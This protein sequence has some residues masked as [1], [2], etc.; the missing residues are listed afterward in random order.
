MSR[1]GRVVGQGAGG[2]C[3]EAGGEPCRAG[4]RF[5]AGSVSKQFVAASALLLSGHGR[6]GLADPVARW[7][8]PAPPAWASM[9]VGHLLANSSGLPHWQGIPGFDVSRPPAPQEILLQAARLPLLSAPG[10]RWAYSGVGYLLAAAIVE[11]AS[12]QPYASFVTGNVFGPLAMT[13][14]TSGEVPG[15]GQAAKGHRDG[16]PVP[17]AAELT[18][19]PGTGDVWTTA[20]DLVRYADA[21]RGGELLPRSSWQLMGHPQVKIEDSLSQAGTIWISAYGYGIY[22]GSIAGHPALFHTG[23]NPG[24]RSLLAW[25]PQAD[26]TFAV[27]ANDESTDLEDIALRLVRAARK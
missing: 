25:L 16:Q 11:A 5:Q 13:A 20:G 9:T 19:M 17:L 27:L 8:A 18:A 26:M 7:W 22:I 4:T 1:R 23:D 2:S 10:T 3:D 15:P 6:L 14:T 12:G 24:F 21:V